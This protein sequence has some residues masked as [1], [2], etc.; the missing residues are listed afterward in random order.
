MNL[1]AYLNDFKAKNSVLVLL[2]VSVTFHIV[3]HGKLFNHPENKISYKSTF[4][5][6]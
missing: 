6:I 3:D 4:K 5:L 2:D 1:S